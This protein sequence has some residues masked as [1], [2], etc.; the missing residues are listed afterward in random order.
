[1]F[2]TLE[3]ADF[4]TL[5]KEKFADKILSVEKHYD[6]SVAT[7]KLDSIKEVIK[8]LQDS[9]FTFLTTCHGI[10]FPDAAE[11]FGMIYHLHDLPRNLRIRLKT[12]TNNEPPTFPTLTDIYPNVNWMERETYDFFG[13]KFTGHPN[14]KRILNVDDM[15]GFP[16]RKEFP[17][18]DQARFDKDDKMFGR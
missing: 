14:L 13:F 1:M 15:E 7:I 10:H 4:E 8:F 11:K 17:L 16:L 5:L 18:E 12:F 6:V 2:Q 3:V 9:G